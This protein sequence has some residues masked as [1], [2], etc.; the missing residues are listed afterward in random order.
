[1]T[2]LPHLLG[3]L[4]YTTYFLQAALGAF[5][6]RRGLTENLGFQKTIVQEDLPATF[7]K[8]GYFGMDERALLDPLSDIASKSKD[9][10]VFITLLT[11]LTH[12]PYA[13][14]GYQVPDE[15]APFAYGT[16]VEYVDDFL[17]DAYQR[18]GA[19]LDWDNTVLIVLG[20]HG[21]AFAEHGLQQ[22]DSV[23]Y[24]EVV[25]IPLLIRFPK[26]IA[27]NVDTTLRQTVDL[28]PSVLEMIGLEWSGTIAGE[29]MFAGPRSRPVVTTCWPTR[30]CHSVVFENGM[31]V[32]YYFG[33]RKEEVY[34]LAHD[35]RERADLS[36]NAGASDLVFE[37]AREIARVRSW[38]EEPFKDAEHENSL[39]AT[40]ESRR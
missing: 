22:H 14:P 18:M 8:A 15:A 23:S 25:R 17:A 34:S 31:K 24:E 9:G 6:N 21:E 20:D 35:P 29:S 5:E 10:P 11:N 4:G 19:Y 27:P 12:H 13:L 32:V 33:P 30:T 38:A 3:K 7:V 26:Q 1:M 16:M 39:P 40:N 28:L 36:S 37:A 2:C